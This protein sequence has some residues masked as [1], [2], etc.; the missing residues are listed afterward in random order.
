VFS[1]EVCAV[2]SGV[3]P[4]SFTREQQRN[5]P[6]IHSLVALGGSWAEDVQATRFVTRPV[7]NIA[8]AEAAAT[9]GGAASLPPHAALQAAGAELSRFSRPVVTHLVASEEAF[10]SGDAPGG[11]RPKVKVLQALKDTHVRLVPLRW[12]QECIKRYSR[13]PEEDFFRGAVTREHTTR[14][15]DA[16]VRDLLSLQLLAA[17]EARLRRELAESMEEREGVKEE[18]KEDTHPVAGRKHPR[19]SSHDDEGEEESESDDS[20]DS[21]GKFLDAL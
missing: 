4:P 17:R 13:L 15:Q 14:P 20:D 5:C 7:V 6:L 8:S 9:R 19:G 21:F 12:L 18:R 1:G 3:F 10:G 11:V 16:R 2:L